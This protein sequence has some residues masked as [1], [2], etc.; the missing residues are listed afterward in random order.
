MLAWP[1]LANGPAS[2]GLV[3]AMSLVISVMNAW[4]SEPVASVAM[5]ESTPITTTTPALIRPTNSAPPI[6]IATAAATGTPWAIMYDAVTALNEAMKPTD[7][8]NVLVQSG[9]T[10]LSAISPV[11]AFSFRIC[12]AVVQVGNVEGAQTVKRTAIA[13]H[14]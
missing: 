10:T 3:I 8:S 7:K 6:A 12:R 1:I 14:T 2:L 9:I 11:A 4:I 13:S 5:N